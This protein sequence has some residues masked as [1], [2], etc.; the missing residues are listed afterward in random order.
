ML[1]EQEA[2]RKFL[3]ENEQLGY[4]EKADSPWSSLWFFIKKKDGTLQLV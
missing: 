4:I 1:V 2:M 3:E